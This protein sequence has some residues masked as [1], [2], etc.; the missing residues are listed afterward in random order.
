MTGNGNHTTYEIGDDWGM[1][2]G[3]VLAT[4]RALSINDVGFKMV[5][6]SSDS[7]PMDDYIDPLQSSIPQEV[8]PND[9]AP[10]LWEVFDI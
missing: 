10:S 6:S 1:V 3:V 5:S 7:W 8:T 9:E 2:Y 4:L